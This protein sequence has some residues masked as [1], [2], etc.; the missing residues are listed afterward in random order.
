MNYETL[1]KNHPNTKEI[2]ESFE[3]GQFVLPVCTDCNKSHWY[4]RP[5]CPHC[6]SQN[7]VLKE[8]KGDGAIH[9]ASYMRKA[10]VPYI[11]ATVTLDDGP[12]ILTNLVG[13]EWQE[14]LIGKRVRLALENLNGL[15]RKMPVF[16]LAD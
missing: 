11:V 3:R 8:S 5:F 9:A 10:K 7:I 1:I 14:N 6:Y 2:W 13:C 15:D 16:Y 12:T 4:P